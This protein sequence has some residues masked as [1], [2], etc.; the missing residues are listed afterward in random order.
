MRAGPGRP[1]MAA[2]L[3]AERAGINENRITVQYGGYHSLA[4]AEFW[5]VSKGGGAP[6][7]TPVER[8]DDDEYLE[9]SDQ[10]D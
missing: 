3:L 6:T 8:P 9:D 5:I 4:E 10:E 1:D 7:P 2:K